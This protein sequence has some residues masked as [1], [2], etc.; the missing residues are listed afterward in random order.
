V[1]PPAVR[2]PLLLQS[3]DNAYGQP[4]PTPAVEAEGAPPDGTPQ[5]AGA[6]PFLFWLGGAQRGEGA[7]RNLMLAA[8]TAAAASAIA[9]A[10]ASSGIR[11]R[12]AV[13]STSGQSLCDEAHAHHNITMWAETLANLHRKIT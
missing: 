2:P 13:C 4:P 10:L 11:D 5:P 6:A 9:F 3:L 7:L 1:L 8:L 12:Q